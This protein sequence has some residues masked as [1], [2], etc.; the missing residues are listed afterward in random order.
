[1]GHLAVLKIRQQSRQNAK[2][3]K[4][5]TD[6]KDIQTN[7]RNGSSKTPVASFGDRRLLT[8]RCIR[9]FVS[10]TNTT[11]LIRANAAK[12][13]QKKKESYLRSPTRT[14]RQT[15]CLLINRPK[16]GT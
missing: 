14:A 11:A 6:R 13:L 2:K 16:L 5:R 10:K 9:Q 1:M 3:Q 12:V 15:E 7:L 8:E 4:E